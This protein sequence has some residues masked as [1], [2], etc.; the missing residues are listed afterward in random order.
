MSLSYKVSGSF[1]NLE[2]FLAHGARVDIQSI[3]ASHGAEGV[4]ALSEAT[5]QDSG[6]AAS[7]WGY[8][9][10]KK[11][12]I[13]SIVWTNDDVEDGFP[14]VVMIQL[15]HGT[16][17]GGWVEGIDFINPAIR[18]IFET[19]ADKILKAVTNP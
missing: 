11:G 8:K 1:K 17:T 15:G 16:G 9:V 7:S 12:A 4:R 13:Y 6:R 3:M 18:P 14:V 5:P 2:A 10:T 19:I